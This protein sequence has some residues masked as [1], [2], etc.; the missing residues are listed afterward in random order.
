MKNAIL[1]AVKEGLRNC[2]TERPRT[3]NQNLYWCG[4]EWLIHMQSNWKIVFEWK[5]QS[6]HENISQTPYLKSENNKKWATFNR[7]PS[8]YSHAYISIKILN[9]MQQKPI[10]TQ[11]WSNEI[12]NTNSKAKLTIWHTL[13]L[14]CVVSSKRD[15]IS[16]TI[17]DSC[18][19]IHDIK[20]S[21]FRITIK[22]FCYA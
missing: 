15:R 3:M 22:T 16:R 19:T 5:V 17:R 12:A 8:Q 9:G 6:S 21:A 14:H 13:S 10:R 1:F 4:F 20:L 11:K 2:F 18:K 7:R